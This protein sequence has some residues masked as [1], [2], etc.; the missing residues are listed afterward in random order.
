M[1]MEK[2]LLFT[3]MFTF[4]SGKRYSVN[5]NCVFGGCYIKD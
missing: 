3:K 4:T 2:E 5:S 1:K